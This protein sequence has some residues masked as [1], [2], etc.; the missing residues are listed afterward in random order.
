MRKSVRTTIKNKDN[1]VCSTY[2]EVGSLYCEGRSSL[3]QP[4]KGAHT[5]MVLEV[6]FGVGC[7]IRWWKERW[8]SPGRSRWSFVVAV[9][10]QHGVNPKLVRWT[11]LKKKRTIERN[12]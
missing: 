1:K 7:A 5:H 11:S 6:P 4:E 8:I 9:E 2:S 12:A 3:G 10:G